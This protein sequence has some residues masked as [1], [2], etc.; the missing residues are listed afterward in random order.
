MAIHGCGMT[1]FGVNSMKSTT[2]FDVL[3]DGEGF[4]V[5]YPTQRPSENLI[6][7]W[8]SSDPRNQLRGAGEAAL[9]AGV[10]RSVQRQARAHRHHDLR[11]GCG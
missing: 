7:C 8:N 1:G 4:I 3:A 9:L 5:V 11:S 2:Q 10:A 6:N